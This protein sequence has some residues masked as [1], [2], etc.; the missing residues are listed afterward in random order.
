[1]QPVSGWEVL[2][3]I[4]KT[5]GY[6][7][8]HVVILGGDGSPS[9]Q[10]KAARLNANACHAKPTTNDELQA[11]IRRIADFWLL[12]GASNGSGG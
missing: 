1:M 5:R 11:L 6:G 7:S 2:E 8:M 4:R 3:W 12:G 10:E 9:D